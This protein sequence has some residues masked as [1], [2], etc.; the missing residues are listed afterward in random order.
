MEMLR[1]IREVEPPKPSTRLSQ[2]RDA[3]SYRAAYR[4]TDSH[5]LLK[6]VRGELDW[7]AMRALEKDRSRRY[8]TASALAADVQRY[9][10]D[11]QV[12]ACPPSL[13]YRLSKFAR[14]QKVAFTIGAAVAA[15]LLLGLAATLWQA[16][17]A[18]QAERDARDAEKV[19]MEKSEEATA[20][21]GKLH[22]A[23]D[24][25]RKAQ[26]IWDMQLI[27]TAWDAGRIDRIQQ[28]LARQ[29]LDLRQFE[30]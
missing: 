27:P 11:E 10:H 8:P 15:T 1:L 12:E 5:R 2:S 28:T 9:L 18:T 6:M 3:L 7:I 25:Q 17:R 20:A 29:T 21:L 24:E 30:W 16:V 23:Q 4:K 13:G 22:A 19:A 14:K 26:Y